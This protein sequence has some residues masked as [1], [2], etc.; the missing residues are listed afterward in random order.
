MFSTLLWPAKR[1]GVTE[2][3]L[4][5]N[6]ICIRVFGRTCPNR[7]ILRNIENGVRIEFYSSEHVIRTVKATS[8]KMCKNSMCTSLNIYTSTL[9][10][11]YVI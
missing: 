1:V 7:R 11:D 8:W 4:D 9:E 5:D 10:I 2:N 3:D 6:E